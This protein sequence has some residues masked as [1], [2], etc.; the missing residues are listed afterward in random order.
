MFGAND[1]IMSQNELKLRL[2][3]VYRFRLFCAMS[4]QQGRTF[5]TAETR[6][7]PMPVLVVF[8]EGKVGVGE[9]LLRLH[10]TVVLRSTCFPEKVGVNKKNDTPV[11]LA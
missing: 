8:V 1:E 11:R 7:I 5:T 9:V 10:S 4:F 6:I 3:F 2:I